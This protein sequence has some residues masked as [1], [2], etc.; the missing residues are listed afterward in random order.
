MAAGRPGPAALET[1]QCPSAFE[2]DGAPVRLAERRAGLGLVGRA[3]RVGRQPA[4]GGR[5]RLPAAPRPLRRG[6]DRP[7][8]AGAGR[9]AVRRLRR[10]GLGGGDGQGHDEAGLH[11]L[12][13]ADRPVRGAPGRRASN[14]R[15][16]PHRSGPG[17]PPASSSRP[18]SALRSGCRRPPT[19]PGWT[20]PSR[21]PCASTS[22]SS[23]RRASPGGRSRWPSSATGRR[24]RP[25]RA[26]SCPAPTSTPTRTSTSTTAP[27]C[28]R[29]PTST[30]TAPTRYAA[31]PWPPSRP[32]AARG[33]PASTSSSRSRA[34][35]PRQRGQHHPRVHADLDVSPAVGGL[36]AALPGAARPAGRAGPRAPRAT[37]RA[38]RPPARPRESRRR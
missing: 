7:G 6:R 21:S 28:A 22:G 8:P 4:G 11:G 14:G 13:A 24:R 10:P 16:G 25:C 19:G 20:R 37:R 5:R 9:P 29:R 23:S 36:R 17:V 1:G 30:P 34:R 26:R 18:T 38:G 27:S 35:L 2:V 3:P 12:R 15:P 33:W 31:W 32:A